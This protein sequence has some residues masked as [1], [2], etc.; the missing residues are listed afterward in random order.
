VYPETAVDV[1]SCSPDAVSAI[2]VIAVKLPHIARIILEPL[3]VYLT[4]AVDGVSVILMEL[5]E[6]YSEMAM[7][8]I[9]LVCLMHLALLA[10]RATS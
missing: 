8:P 1:V 10:F 4:D 3:E 6:I 2:K 5:T 7:L 9:S